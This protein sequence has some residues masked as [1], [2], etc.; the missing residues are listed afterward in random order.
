MPSPTTR[1]DSKPGHPLRTW[2]GRLAL[3]GTSTLLALCLCELLLRT[4]DIERLPNTNPDLYQPDAD[5][6]YRMK[7]NASVYSHGATFETNELG[8]RGPT[9]DEVR[10]AGRDPVLFVGDSVTVGF[11]VDWEESYAG[12]LQDEIPEWEGV[13]VAACGYGFEQEFDATFEVLDAVRPAAVVWTFVS[14]DF[15]EPYP[16]FQPRFDGEGG[17]ALEP[18]KKW[19]RRKS[20]LYA[21]LRKRWSHFRHP[22]FAPKNRGEELSSELTEEGSEAK[23]ERFENRFA[24]LRAALEDKTPLVLTT[25]PFGIPQEA[26]AR[27]RSIAERQGATWID[28]R[29]LWSDVAIY[30]EHGSLGWDGHPN[31]RSHERMAQKIAG[32]LRE[33]N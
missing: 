1:S 14:N 12:R 31:P 23:W 13:A 28:M 8:W 21:F 4:L 26:E 16:I 32:A 18:L 19:L 22:E 2:L 27:L 25:F 24:E 10:A 17:G 11:G 7:P 29:E 15:E 5:L 30:L 33:E 6:V 3:A 20:V 9:W